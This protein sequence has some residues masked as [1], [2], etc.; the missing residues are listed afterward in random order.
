MPDVHDLIERA[1]QHLDAAAAIVFDADGNDRKELAASHL[2]RAREL[3][4]EADAA[5]G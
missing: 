2:S 3:L 1:R 5:T 4:A